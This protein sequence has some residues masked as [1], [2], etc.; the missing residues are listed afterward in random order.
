MKAN[1]ADELIKLDSVPGGLVKHDDNVFKEVASS[2]DF[3]PRVQLMTSSS[4]KC[5]TGEFPINHYA[6]IR[7]QAHEDLGTAVDVLVVA[8]RP[9]ALDTND[10]VIS[11]YDPADPQFARIK[12]KSGEKD[13]GC[14]FGPE[15][16]LYIPSKKEFATF[17]MGSKSSRRESPNVKARLQKAAT[18]KANRIETPA[19]TWYAPMVQPCS[20]PFDL[21]EHDDLMEVVTKFNNPPK[22]TVEK[23]APDSGGGR[24]R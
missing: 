3:F 2:G 12:E 16:L 18:L 11:V 9:K 4:D 22:P 14:M 23:V 24:A 15:F 21:P 10:P 7:D 20:T 5:K 13:S 19:Y 17:F 6:L 1:M 8:W